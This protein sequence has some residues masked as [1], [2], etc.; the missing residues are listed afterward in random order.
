MKYLFLSLICAFILGSCGQKPRAEITSSFGENFDPEGAVPV[1]EV[2]KAMENKDTL[3]V[4]FIAKIT[5]TCTKAGCWMDVETSPGETMTVFML[6][7]AFGVP[8]EGCDGLMATINGTAY[9]DTL[10]VKYQRHLAEDAGKTI[11]EIDA[12]TEPKP[13]LAVDASGVMIAGYQPNPGSAEENHLEEEHH[14]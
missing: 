1:A 8:L 6:D 14:H 3:S 10:S 2:I 12:I 11:E 7:H 13:V 5:Q 9:Y 4:K